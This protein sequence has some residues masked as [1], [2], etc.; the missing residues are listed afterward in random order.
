MNC[1]LVRSARLKDFHNGD[2]YISKNQDRTRAILASPPRPVTCEL[3]P[4]SQLLPSS[5]SSG[6][7]LLRT[8]AE[9]DCQGNPASARPLAASGFVHFSLVNDQT[10]LTDTANE[11]RLL[12]GR[13][14]L[15][16]AGCDRAL[17]TYYR[18][19]S[20]TILQALWCRSLWCKSPPG[21]SLAS[22]STTPPFETQSKQM[23]PAH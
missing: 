9:R 3:T 12:D 8:I 16:R 23:P 19:L 1:V 5:R 10:R 17:L 7:F 13:R 15:V 14:V 20:F 22:E 6:P 2:S 18:A 4:Y 21:I 11:I